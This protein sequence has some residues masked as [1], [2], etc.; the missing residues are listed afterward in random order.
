[1][2]LTTKS[3]YGVRA[4]INLAMVYDR[5]EALSVGSVSRKE[6]LSSDYLEQIFNRLRVRGLVK[7]VRGPKGGY[8]LA[9]DPSKVSVYDIVMALEEGIFP[10]RC[11]SSGKR[12]EAIC[13]KA[14]SCVSR[15]VWGEVARQ[16]EETLA[17]F[18][19]RGM[20]ER[21]SKL[22]AKLDKKVKG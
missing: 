7:S 11:F 17:R 13:A 5:G 8:L 15:E 10:G 14:E 2:R 4:L 16:I 21:A 18:S 22:A 20:A 9:R 1:M 19:L 3:S 12:K 6:G